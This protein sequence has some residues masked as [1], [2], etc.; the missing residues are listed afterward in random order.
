MIQSSIFRRKRSTTAAL[1][2]SKKERIEW[3]PVDASVSWKEEEGA[4]AAAENELSWGLLELDLGHELGQEL[5][6]MEVSCFNP[7]TIKERE[8]IKTFYVHS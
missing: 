7:D 2:V 1:Y 8:R 5:L 4:A 6:L 3:E